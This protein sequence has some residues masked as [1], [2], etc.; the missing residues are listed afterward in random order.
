MFQ[1]A[2]LPLLLMK[3]PLLFLLC[4]LQVMDK[5]DDIIAFVKT[6]CK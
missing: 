6:K 3:I 4:W 1:N 2:D 5:N